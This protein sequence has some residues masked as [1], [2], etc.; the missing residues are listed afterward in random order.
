MVS[1]SASGD[2][3]SSRDSSEDASRRS[4]KSTYY[5]RKI[6]T[7]QQEKHE[8]TEQVNE[9]KAERG[10][11]DMAPTLEQNALLRSG[12]QAAGWAMAEAQSVLSN[13]MAET[14]GDAHLRR[15]H[16]QVESTEASNGDILIEQFAVL[17]FPGVSSI[18][19]VYEALLLAISHQEF[20]VWEN[21]GVLAMCEL[22]DTTDYSAS[23]SRYFTKVLPGLDLEKNSASFRQYYDRSEVLASPHGLVVIDFV[24]ED[25]LYPYHP[26]SRVRL[27]VSG[28]SMVCHSED[29]SVSIVRWSRA[30]IHRPKD[31]I[32]PQAME[33]FRD[34]IPR[35]A[36]V[37]N[38]TV[39][40]Y[41]AEGRRMDTEPVGSLG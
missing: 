31:G 30:R 3:T 29:D 12:L 8:L 27:D 35:W 4:Y 37:T 6:T 34:F 19:H 17:P 21:L 41:V 25:E 38:K 10:V 24:D 40:E 7:L 15:S 26:E 22:E 20:T 2:A 39:R 23:Q 11:V 18:K 13:R 16:R 14:S 5:A 9:L 1:A 36:E 28:M 32:P 33:S